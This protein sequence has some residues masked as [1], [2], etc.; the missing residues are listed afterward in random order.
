VWALVQEL[1]MGLRRRGCE[2][3]TDLVAAASQRDGLT[4]SEPD[5]I[6]GEQALEPG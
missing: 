6:V 4:G 5:D 1:E 2:D 3:P